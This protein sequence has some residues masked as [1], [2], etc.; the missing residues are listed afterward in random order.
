VVE[1]LNVSG[2]HAGGHRLYALALARTEQPLQVDGRPAALL[3]AP[4]PG[5]ERCE[6]SLELG[7]PVGFGGGHH[8]ASRE[9]HRSLQQI[10]L[11]Q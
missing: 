4:E 5:Q 10:N 2:R 8:G 6:P 3:G 7:L 9:H 11:A 1:L